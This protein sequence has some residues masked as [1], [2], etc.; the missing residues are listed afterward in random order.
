MHNIDRTQL[1]FESDN[2]SYE[3]ESE[4]APCKCG[5][6]PSNVLNEV[7]E[8]ELAAELLEV[9]DEDEL[10]QFLGK[11][12]KR[13]ARGV[14]K[15][16][17]SPIGGALFKALKGAALT[18]VPGLGP[19]VGAA[20]ALGSAVKSVAKAAAPEPTTEDAGEIFG[21]E[22]EG[23]SPQ[24][25]EFEVARR[26]VRFG[27]EAVAQISDANAVS[28]EQAAHEAVDRAAARHAP[29][30]RNHRRPPQPRGGY[31]ATAQSQHHGQSGRWVRRGRQI[32]LLDM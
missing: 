25:Q 30:L 15:F 5:G 23:M 19:V 20:T 12:I 8:M 4:Q 31:G 21:L 1:E 32:I 26:F 13:V 11:F 9:N 28:P 27:A 17:K 29:G 3:F 22:L 6:H 10:D 24:D 2:E 14:K 7:D 16:V 18:A